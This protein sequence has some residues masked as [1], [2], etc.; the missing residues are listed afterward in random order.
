MGSLMLH[1]AQT[2]INAATKLQASHSFQRNHS[3]DATRV[4]TLQTPQDLNENP[5]KKL[6]LT[7]ILMSR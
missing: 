1:K 2:D 4:L 6:N 5:Y 7:L 3:V